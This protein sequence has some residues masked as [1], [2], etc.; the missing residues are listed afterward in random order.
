MKTAYYSSPDSNRS[1]AT[2]TIIDIFRDHELEISSETHDFSAPIV[3]AALS[4]SLKSRGFDCAYVSDSGSKKS[5]EFPSDDH[6]GSTILKFDAFHRLSGTALVVL[7]GQ[8]LTNNTYLKSMIH[9]SL[10][11][12]VRHLVL[13]VRV[14]YRRSEDFEKIRDFLNILMNSHNTKLDL[15]SLTLIGY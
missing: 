10:A 15:D 1:E 13:G 2:T 12:K 6:T 3:F 8:G 4:E 5:L 9:A 14:K 7:A 11:P